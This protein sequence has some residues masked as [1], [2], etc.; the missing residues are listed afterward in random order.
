MTRPDGAKLECEELT[1]HTE[2]IDAGTEHLEL[3]QTGVATSE[4]CLLNRETLE[5]PNMPMTIQDGTVAVG[6]EG[7][8]TVDTAGAAASSLTFKGEFFTD[9][10]HEAK[11]AECHFSGN[12][13]L[14]AV[15]SDSDELA[16]G[17][18]SLDGGP[19]TK[20]GVD[21]KFTLETAN[22]EPVVIHY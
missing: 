1:L 22:G 11:V 21:G 8:V 13:N 14:Q 9:A 6:E 12:L 10:E 15:K 20:G 19:C 7:L 3:E 16:I 4:D 5:L 18:S 17:S 2:L